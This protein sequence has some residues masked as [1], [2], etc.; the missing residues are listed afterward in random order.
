MLNET[1]KN[2]ESMSIFLRLLFVAPSITVQTLLEGLDS[3]DEQ[4]D[5]VEA[6]TEKRLKAMKKLSQRQNN[7]D[8]L[9][10]LRMAD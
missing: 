8:L 5:K 4:L 10:Y 9:E 7:K 2:P 6:S 3:F 1:G